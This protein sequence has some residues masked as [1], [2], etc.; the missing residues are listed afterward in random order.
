M[1]K[2]KRLTIL[3]V[4]AVAAFGA[5]TATACGT[6]FVHP[7]G[8]PDAA[9]A[10]SSNGGFI[11]EKGEYVYFIN[12]IESYTE[13]NVYGEVV[14]ASLMRAKKSDI[15]AGDSKAEIVVPQLM[16]AGDH[17]S[18]IY[19]YGNRVYF[20]TPNNVKNTEGVIESNYLTFKSA[21]LDGSDVQTYFNADDNAAEYRFVQKGDVVYVMYKDGNDLRSYN[22]VTKADTLLAQNTTAI[23]FD[24][25][26]VTNPVAYYTMAVTE[27]MDKESA[28]Q[29]KYNQIYSVSADATVAPYTYTFDEEYLNDYKANN[30]GKLPYVNLG[31]IVLDG[32][33]NR[34]VEKKG[35][36]YVAN[37]FTHETLSATTLPLAPGGYTYTLVGYQNG[38]LYFSRSEIT[39]TEN[40]T[41]WLFYLADGKSAATEWNSVLG[42]GAS[43]LD[44][45]AKSS[46]NAT[47]EALYYIDESGHHYLF[48]DG[49][50]IKRADVDKTTGDTKIVRIAINSSEAT[51]MNV[52]LTTDAT[53]DYVYYTMANGSGLSVNRAVVNNEFSNLSDDKNVEPV[54]VLDIQHS[55]GWYS[56]EIIGGRLYYADCESFNGTAYNQISSVNLLKDGKMMTNSELI[57]YNESY[58][59]VVD[60]IA[61]VQGD[62]SKLGVAINYYY[63]TASR[64]LF[65][66][67]IAYA[68]ENG[69]ANDYLYDA[70]EQAAFNAYVQGKEGETDLSFKDVRTRNKFITKVGVLNEEKTEKYE[71]YW[72][73]QLQ[74]YT[75]PTEAEGLPAWAWALIG[76]AIGLVVAAAIIVPILVI[77]F[78]KK[79]QSK[80]ESKR[81]PKMFV[82]TTDDKSL[83]VYADEEDEMPVGMMSDID[84]EECEEVEREALTED[85]LAAALAE[86]EAELAETEQ[87]AEA[88]QE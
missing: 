77:Y 64:E 20:A 4:A 29:L 59:E 72:Q 22:T 11:V 28:T 1:R 86:E 87:D 13:S 44:I 57:A 38:G 30:K 73:N 33:G 45:I 50:S 15:N 82:D 60:Y 53:Y 19:V 84:F 56:A 14:N 36:S 16:S 9:S 71:Y 70:D 3:S 83:D 34:D 79:K 67:N 27:D 88:E 81:K 68:V 10:V 18:G 48:V 55:G 75:V 24:K 76:V 8:M 39:A 61:D 32:I 47:D 69:E 58:Q 78:K 37:Q 66:E 62:N 63:Y 41:A 21:L 25:G 74:H 5:L 80:T 12:G 43:S 49:G 2:L 65:D 31:K 23:L 40:E 6:S 85:E 54:K 42:N 52:D 7:S 17:S 46:T 51:L 26:D 35:E